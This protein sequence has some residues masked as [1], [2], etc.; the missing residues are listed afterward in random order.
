MTTGH[1]LT[2]TRSQQ[3]MTPTTQTSSRNHEATAINISSTSPSTNASNT[4]KKR[5][6]QSF[7]IPLV[8]VSRHTISTWDQT[9]ASLY[10]LDQI[11]SIVNKTQKQWM[12][13]RYKKQNTHPSQSAQD[14]SQTDVFFGD[15][16]FKPSSKDF[17]MFLVCLEVHL[18][19]YSFKPASERS[20]P[21]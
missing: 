15:I 7:D 10:P 8:A 2:A 3:T 9:T 14:L 4:S 21:Y 1:R 13:T 11:S 12:K 18:S 20:L 19:W 17:L 6:W 5:S 16:P